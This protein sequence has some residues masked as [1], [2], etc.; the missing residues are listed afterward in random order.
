MQHV[1]MGNGMDD[2]EMGPLISSDALDAVHA[3]HLRFD[4]LRFKK[5]C[6]NN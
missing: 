1:K 6:L 3:M 5:N 2:P 4:I